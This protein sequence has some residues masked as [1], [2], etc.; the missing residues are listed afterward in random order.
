MSV[1]RVTAIYDM[2]WGW[3]S[4]YCAT[5]LLAAAFL[6]LTYAR[7]GEAAA[8]LLKSHSLAILGS[9]SHLAA[10]V[11]GAE[12]GDEINVW[13]SANRAKIGG[14]LQPHDGTTHDQAE[15]PTRSRGSDRSNTALRRGNSVSPSSSSRLVGA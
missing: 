7:T 10:S 12:E 14:N 9:G 13:A 5:L 2:Q 1:G 4:L 8:P 11:A 6:Y 3:I 15:R